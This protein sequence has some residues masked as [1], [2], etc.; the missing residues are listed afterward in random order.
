VS[1]NTEPELKNV[2]EAQA[3]E[4]VQWALDDANL[5]LTETWGTPLPSTVTAERAKLVEKYLAA[6]FWV[7]AAEKGGLT[8]EKAGDATNAYQK[9]NGTGLGSTRFGQQVQNLD[10]TG[11]IDMVLSYSRKA[12]LRVV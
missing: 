5:V 11:Q 8:S 10:P 6:H 4:S 12:Q 9:V 1:W 3:G 7:V 2:I